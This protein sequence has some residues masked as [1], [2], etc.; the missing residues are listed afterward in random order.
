M[1]RLLLGL[2]LITFVSI[3]AGS[4]T[5][6]FFQWWGPLLVIVAWIT[7]ASIVIVLGLVDSQDDED[8]S[9]IK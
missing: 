5:Y 1:K 3:I 6:I 8:N 2:C 9:P 7:I 4:L